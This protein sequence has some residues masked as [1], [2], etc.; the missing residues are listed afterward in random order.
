MSSSSDDN[1]VIINSIIKKHPYLDYILCIPKRNKIINSNL[2]NIQEERE[3]EEFN[4]W[5]Q[6]KNQKK[7]LKQRRQIKKDHTFHHFIVN[8]D[9]I[10][11]R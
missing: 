2:E 4:D 7:R 5:T 1:L 8:Q 11:K 9:L 6:S 3:E 10:L